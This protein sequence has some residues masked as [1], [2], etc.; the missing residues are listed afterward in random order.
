MK[1]T[2]CLALFLGLCVPAGGQ[3]DSGGA[4]ASLA[5][6]LTSARERGLREADS[7]GV[8]LS[9]SPHGS[10]EALCRLIWQ[11]APPTG[12]ERHARPLSPWEQS[13][14]VEALRR[15][16]KSE[17]RKFL[18]LHALTKSSSTG[19]KLE[20]MKV[21][22]LA[23]GRDLFPLLLRVA[24]SLTALERRLPGPLRAFERATA[25][26]L[27]RDPRCIGALRSAASKLSEE[28]TLL[29]V[30]AMGRVHV[31]G[32]DDV[33]L[34]L[35]GRSES[36]DRSVLAALLRGPRGHR[37]SLMARSALARCLES[38]RDDIRVL[39]A[40]VVASL[41]EVDLTPLLIQLLGATSRRVAKA[42]EESLAALSNRRLGGDASAW[43]AWYEKEQQWI[44]N[45]WPD[46]LEKILGSEGGASTQAFREALLHPLYRDI[47]SRDLV[48]LL[49]DADESLCRIL[50]SFLGNLGSPWSED[51]LAALTHD[52][53][54]A[55]RRE[56]VKALR[57]IRSKALQRSR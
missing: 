20:V 19:E 52:P 50:C 25:E 56:A 11:G 4:I 36:L 3:E 45:R 31:R 29:L 40:R 53:R 55:V 18:E 43:Q 30:Q 32:I 47:I 44:E 16:P 15:R 41:H 2:L 54:P 28:E 51:G 17:L 5:K 35:L 57:F 22:E 27:R 23:G 9:S 46:L 24:G 37:P 13:A 10:S 6:I 49:P 38:N 1:R 34:G 14:V 42:A 21:I 8:L 39:A 12:S 48:E 33:L 26:L 7:V